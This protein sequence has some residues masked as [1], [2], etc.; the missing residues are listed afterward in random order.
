M[1]HENKMKKTLSIVALLLTFSSLFAKNLSLI[2]GV[3]E[4]FE[5]L[6]G[7]N[8]K[9]Y[10]EDA[11]LIGRPN[12]TLLVSRLQLGFIYKQT[13]DIIYNS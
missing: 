1:L 5:S 4:R 10:G 7:M 9:A 13:P 8:K 6:D 3:R 12:D 2:G 11:S